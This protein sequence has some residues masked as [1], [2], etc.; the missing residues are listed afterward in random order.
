[1]AQDDAYA[2]AAVT[3]VSSGST[4]SIIGT[5]SHASAGTLGR[6]QIMRLV[7]QQV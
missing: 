6:W 7:Q 5:A 1:M 4:A 2:A 3:G